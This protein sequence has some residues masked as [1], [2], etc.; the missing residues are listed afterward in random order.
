MK[1]KF[2]Y[3]FIMLALLFAFSG[4]FLFA[5]KT[6]AEPII[7]TKSKSAILMEANSKK[8]LYSK[9]ELVHLPIASMCKVMTLLVCFEE[10]DNSNLNLEDKIIVSE[11][12]SGMGGSQIFLEANGE[13]LVSD[14]I[15]GIIVASAND[16]CVALAERLYGSETLFVD[17]MNDKCKQ[18]NMNDTNF[19]NCTGLP[20]QN[21]YSCARD[22]GI[23]FSELI[24]HKEYF[25]YSNI[26]MDE[27][28]H[29]NNRITQIS[30]TNKLV[31]FYDGCEGGKTGYT[32]QAGHCLTACAK[33]NDLR[34]IS[35]VIGAPDS[36]TRFAEV[37]NM[38]NYGFSNYCNKKILSVDNPLDFEV[39]VKGG[40]QESVKVAPEQNFSI[41][42]GKNEK[43]VI[44]LDYNVDKN[45]KAPIKKGDVVGTVSVYN[46]NVMVKEVNIVSVD[47]V[48]SMNYFENLKNCIDNW[49]LI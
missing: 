1:Y 7:E 37:S 8:I 48:V 16:A 31:K 10:I 30:N 5:K 2:S 9:D 15:K 25:D 26:W 19:V 44:D 35:V 22:V 4:M 18:L 38:F 47:D 45:I 20:Q 39:D 40:K 6:Y 23:M 12:A 29:P 42:C 11:R 49:K 43:I 3:V 14:L 34:F 17:K 32:K 21:Q 24:K 46:N 36:K 27:I 33:R 41:F 28:N 13:Y